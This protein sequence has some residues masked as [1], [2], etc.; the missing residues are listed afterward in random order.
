MEM[1]RQYIIDFGYEDLTRTS[2]KKYIKGNRTT[3]QILQLFRSDRETE[4][5]QRKDLGY[6]DL[7]K[8]NTMK[9]FKGELLIL[10]RLN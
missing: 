2:T 4:R 1:R 8:A 10:Q 9:W 3:T 7:A 5:K 6:E